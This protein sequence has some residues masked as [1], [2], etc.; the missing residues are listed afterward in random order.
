[1]LVKKHPP[2]LVPALLAGALLAACGD[3]PA[4]PAPLADVR[5]LLG[6]SQAASAV[7]AAKA[8]VAS[9]PESAE[10]R[11]LLGLG[12][13]AA[14]EAAAA[15]IEL[16]RALELGQPADDVLPALAQALLGQRKFDALGGPFAQRRPARADAA[17]SFLTH[18]AEA[19]AIQGRRDE[20]RRLVAEALQAQAQ[21][22]AARLLEARLN[23]ADGQTEAA[24]QQL[25]TLLAST[26]DDPD[27][28]LF[29]ADLLAAMRAPA[30]ARTEALN[31][32]LAIR[33]DLADAHAGLIGMALA[34]GDLA[35]AQAR[36]QRLA[37]LLPR[38][39]ATLYFE[40]VL[41]EENGDLARMREIAQGLL[42]RAPQ[43]TAVLM[44]AGRAA[45]DAGA[46]GQ[47]TALLTQAARLAP[48]NAEPSRLLAQAFVRTGW[49]DKALAVL[50]PFTGADAS[51]ADALALAAQALQ[52]RGDR[53]G[54]Q[55]QLRRAMALR[56]DDAGLRL[57]WM[58]LQPGSVG[59]A[60][61]MAPLQAL[62]AS[63]RTQDTLA[64]V[65]AQLARRDFAAAART[66]E[67]LSRQR[68]DWAVP[69]ELRGHLALLQ[70]DRE[71]ARG[72]FQRA[73]DKQPGHFT[74]LL[75]LV[76]LDTAARQPESALRRLDG[77]LA[78]QPRHLEA[79]L[80]KAA[81]LRERKA[82][83]PEV[84][85]VLAEAVRAHP[86]DPKAHLAL[87]GALDAAQ[88][89]AEML[90][91]ARAATAAIPDHVDL[92]D[93]LGVA[94][95]AN[96]EL[97]QAETTFKRL[98]ALQSDRAHPYVRLAEVQLMRA[99][100][101]N[102]RHS[103]RMARQVEADDPDALRA[104]AAMALRDG[105]LADAQQ[106]AQEARTRWP[107]QTLGLLL[108]ADV[109]AAGQ[110]WPAAEQAYRAALALQPGAPEITQRLHDVLVAAERRDAARQLLDAWSA[111][112]PGDLA[113]WQHL[114]SDSLARRDW[115]EAEAR[116]RQLLARAPNDVLV[117]NNLAMALASQNNPE[118]VALA[119][120]AVALSA[121]QPQVL[122]TLARAYAASGQL[123][124]AVDTQRRAVLQAP[125]DRALLLALAQLQ[126]RAGEA[127]K[128]RESFIQ[129]T[130]IGLGTPLGAEAEQLRQ[131]LGLPAGAALQGN[132]AWQTTEAD[133]ARPRAAETGGAP[134]P[135]FAAWRERA[136]MLLT[137][138]LALAGLG[139]AGLGARAAARPPFIS[140]TREL[141]L[142]VP[143]ALLEAQLRDLRQWERCSTLPAFRRT[144]TRQLAP[145]SGPALQCRWQGPGDGGSVEVFPPE[146]AGHVLVEQVFGSR[147]DAP[148]QLW[149][150]ELAAGP[151]GGTLL[152][153]T[154]RETAGFAQ[155]LVQPL[156]G[157][158]RRIGRQLAQELA[159]WK[160]ALQA[161]PAT[162]ATVPPA[163][164]A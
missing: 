83:Q 151:D 121:Q 39:T 26:P 134:R 149:D 36:Q 45:L 95:M 77:F 20:A 160:A 56:P 137:G 19:Q 130:R 16:N 22:P 105:R 116:Y 143:P 136:E 17:A 154:A 119:E 161:A 55:A 79:L 8:A 32:A 139:L 156:T 37:Q 88:R 102:A 21:H 27:L 82:P 57:A 142:A 128:A 97:L 101:D 51:D 115:P 147:P 87:I 80:A 49:P 122:D 104:T 23:A 10:A 107:A 99:Q 133:P 106:L 52:L 112:H 33:P 118:A 63:G 71:A 131:A 111:D 141:A 100:P 94:Q 152:R 120:K 34:A 123:A 62:A 46:F 69:D 66:L 53:S 150:F 50:K 72:H 25:E 44:L 145:A 114:A 135:G 89:P 38:H 108:E 110:Q 132:A 148:R 2:A 61:A 129:L 75:A 162:A 144:A 126:L 48:R 18:L 93:R 158:E 35:T 84:Q 11:L 117:L 31:R 41:A 28:W 157:R 140:V 81:L 59:D 96:S 5:A 85:A 155:R 109:A 103:L 29:K 68:P 159:A 65:K 6:A 164:P 1:M 30:E 146:L 15:E 54:A 9:R 64:L 113:L 3:K 67:Q 86:H 76:Q 125:H 42:R 78:R 47:A 13:L 124:Q 14:G 98:A 7:V 24:M 127:E 4:G 163:V 60:A 12:L 74:A 92:M 58:L 138:L 73:L 91:A 153:C 43:D 70:R 40:A 90:V